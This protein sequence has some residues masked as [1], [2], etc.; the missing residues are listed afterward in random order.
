MLTWKFLFG[1]S[2]KNKNTSIY[3]LVFIYQYIPNIY[4]Y[5]FA[6]FTVVAIIKKL[7]HT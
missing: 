2:Y 3:I 5:I 6:Y 7:E 1:D 4:I